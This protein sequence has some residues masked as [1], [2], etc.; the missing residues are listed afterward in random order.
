MRWPNAMLGISATLMV[1]TTA[2]CAEQTTAPKSIE[3]IASELAFKSCPPFLNGKLALND[4]AALAEM[5]FTAK[6]AKE[7]DALFGDVEIVTAERSDGT[8]M[9]GGRPQKGCRVLVFGSQR[10]AALNRLRSGISSV[11]ANFKADPSKTGDRGPLKVETYV[12]PVGGNE[13]YIELVDH[14]ESAPLVSYGLFM[15][16]K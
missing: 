12:A 5:G 16:R 11:N 10:S 9:F 13:L 14:G 15:M 7:V 8:L 2:A 1:A 3:D 6:G 4:N